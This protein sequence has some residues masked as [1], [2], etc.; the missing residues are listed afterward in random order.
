MEE[1]TQKQGLNFRVDTEFA[2]KFKASAQRARMKQNEY[3]RHLLELD[4]LLEKR[5]GYGNHNS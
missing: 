5:F 3:L 2:W 1:K 4:E